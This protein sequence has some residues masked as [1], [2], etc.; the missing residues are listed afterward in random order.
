[1]ERSLCFALAAASAACLTLATVPVSGQTATWYI[2]TYTNDILVW[3]EASEEIVD[4]IR[5]PHLVPNRM[6]LGADRSRIYVGEASAQYMQVVDVA[7]GDVVDEFTLSRDSIRVRIDA[8]SPHP[9]DERM[10]VAVK[11]YTKHRDRYSVRGPFLLE[12]DLGAG[13]VTDTIPWPD[14][15]ARDRAQFRYAPDGRTL[16]LFAD[17]IIAIDAETHDVVDRWEIS[18]PLGPGLGRPGFGTEPGT[19]DAPGPS[20]ASFA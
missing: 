20:R 17:D 5:V 8:F 11:E 14:G 12:Y 4:R 16:Y 13:R 6:Q 18:E 15:H 10:V 9:S 7:S 1:M 2:G 3:D 19:Y